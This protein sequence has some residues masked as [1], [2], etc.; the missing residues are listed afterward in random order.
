MRL[1]GTI[2]DAEKGGRS[3][4]NIARFKLSQ[5][6][7]DRISKRRE[8]MRTGCA[9]WSDF[10]YN[11]SATASTLAAGSTATP[12]A[13]RSTAH[14]SGPRMPLNSPVTPIRRP[15]VTLIGSPGRRPGHLVEHDRRGARRLDP[16]LARTWAALTIESRK[17]ARWRGSC[18]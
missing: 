11:Y 15:L 18:A 17:A 5:G 10:R 6:N 7:D 8:K 9:H 1:G 12:S 3:S 13:A 14:R 4:R 2:K 16:G